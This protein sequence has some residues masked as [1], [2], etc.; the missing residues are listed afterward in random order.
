VL[1]WLRGEPN[2]ASEEELADCVVYDI[3]VLRRAAALG[4]KLGCLA[5]SGGTYT[6]IAQ[7]TEG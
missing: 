1:D 4:V 2:G 6:F 5:A 7:G 3:E